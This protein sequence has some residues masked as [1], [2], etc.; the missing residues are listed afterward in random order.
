MLP[1]ADHAPAGGQ[2]PRVGIPVPSDVCLEFRP[3]PGGVGFGPSSVLRANVPKT[4]IYEDGYFCSR[5]KD[6]RG[7]PSARQWNIDAVSEA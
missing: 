4:A 7:A 1:D 5:E 2:Q 3:P 6:I